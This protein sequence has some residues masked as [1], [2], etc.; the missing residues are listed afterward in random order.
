MN[1]ALVAIVKNEDA[2]IDEWLDYNFSIGFTHAF[3][4]QNNWRYAGDKARYDNVTWIEF[5]G[6]ERQLH[7]YNDFLFNRSAGYDFAAFIDVDEFIVLNKDK[8]LPT[9]LADFTEEQAVSLNWKLF[10][11]SH[12]DFDGDC[13]VI[14]RFTWCQ[15]GFNEHVKTIVNLNKR[16]TNW[17]FNNP[18]FVLR[19]VASDADKTCHFYSPLNKQCK[20]TRAWINHYRVK[21]KQE[22]EGKMA[23]GR[24]DTLRPSCRYTP[25]NFTEWNMNEVQDFTLRDIVYTRK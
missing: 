19:C 18:H 14:K 15:R 7:A 9:F 23:R 6:E 21:T 24:V 16:Q 20:A 13:S 8:D 3:I 25:D 1:I 22:Y 17:R 4:Y 11:D 2:Y 5:D 12:L 10:G